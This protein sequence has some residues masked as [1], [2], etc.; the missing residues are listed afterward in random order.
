MNWIPAS[1]HS[2][3]LYRVE[4]MLDLIWILLAEAKRI[5]RCSATNLDNCIGKSGK[6]SISWMSFQIVGN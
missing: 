3:V 5:Q 6:E 2:Q 4:K 1:F